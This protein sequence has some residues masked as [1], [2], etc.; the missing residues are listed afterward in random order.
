[1][2][3]RNH[4][5]YFWYGRCA[6]L[7]DVSIPGELASIGGNDLWIGR[8]DGLNEAGLAIGIT[9]VMGGRH[10]PGIMFPLAVR[11]ILN[12][13]TTTEAA[14]AFLERIPY[15]R[16]NNFL[17]A[18]AAGTIAIVEVSPK[19]VNVTYATNGFG[20]ITN[21]FQSERMAL[22]ENVKHRP[23]H[24]LQRLLRLQ[25]WFRDCQEAITSSALQAII[26]RPYP[27]GVWTVIKPGKHTIFGTVWSWVAALGERQMYFAEG[28]PQGNAGYRCIEF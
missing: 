6:A 16:N 2:F 5:W 15:I 8:H 3:A 11:H 28:T 18:D 17:V 27:G 12:T 23:A 4:D 19:R 21:H 24:S 7:I 9:N 10:T 22:L 13:C 25:A 20:V 26:G 1:L 14:V